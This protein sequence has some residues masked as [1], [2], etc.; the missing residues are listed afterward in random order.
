MQCFPKSGDAQSRIAG[1]SIRT[2]FS[3]FLATACVSTL[4]ADDIKTDRSRVNP[5]GIHS[6]SQAAANMPLMR[7]LDFSVGNSFFRNPW[8]AAPASTDARDGLGPLFNTNACQNC[9]IKDGRG[10][11]PVNESDNAV[12]LLLR[13]NVAGAKDVAVDAPSKADPIYGG[14]LQ[15]FA[16]PG[17]AAEGQISIRYE[18]I[19]VALADGSKRQLR[20]PIFSIRDLAYG[21]LH[22]DTQISA[23]VAPAMV[24]LGLLEAIPE[25]RLKALADPEDRDQNGISGRLNQVWDIKKKSLQPGRFGWKAGQPSLEQQ[26]AGA[27]NGDMGI[28]SSLFPTENCSTQQTACL[29]LA[30]AGDLSKLEVSD[31]ILDQVTFYTSNLAVPKRRNPKNQ[32]VLAGE[33]IFE[34]IGCSGCHT[35]EHITSKNYPFSWLAATKIAPYT[36]L[37]LHDMGPELADGSREFVASGS[38]WRTPPL[39]GLGM[40]K[41]V[42]GVE[43]LLHDGRARNAEEAILWHGGEAAQANAHYKQL[44]QKEREQL[45]AFLYDL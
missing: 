39:W 16:L 34:R 6:F 4:A 22:K 27:F 37:L 26:N 24:G 28:R 5:K 15:D 40:I 36:D 18:D 17:L 14:Q 25:E 2:L 10:H 42:N 11:L 12:S 45:L 1:I 13:L 19:T 21:P 44:S 8:V 29:K 38:E 23:R 41:D 31:K 30:K 35:A 33:K 43:A 32:D 20:K 3:A 7:R 9:H